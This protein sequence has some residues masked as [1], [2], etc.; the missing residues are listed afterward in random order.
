MTD[1]NS[2]SFGGDVGKIKGTDFDRNASVSSGEQVYSAPHKEIDNLD[3][4]HAALVGRSMVKKYSGTP[5]FDGKLVASV[6]EDLAALDANYEKNK[7]SV[8]I[9]DL[10]LQRGIPYEQAMKMGEEFRKA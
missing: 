8:A 7:K 2:S 9:E 5:K 4:A 6:K 1:I 10:A 3:N